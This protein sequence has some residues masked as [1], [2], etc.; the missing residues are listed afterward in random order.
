VLQKCQEACDEFQNHR[1]D[2][3]G[4]LGEG[5]DTEINPTWFRPVLDKLKDITE[6]YQNLL[7]SCSSLLEHEQVAYRIDAKFAE[8]ATAL[9]NWLEVESSALGE[10]K[11]DQSSDVERRLEMV[12]A[13][14]ANAVLNGEQQCDAVKQTSMELCSCLKELGASERAVDDVTELVA[15][16]RNELTELINAAGDLTNQLELEK[17][18]KVGSVGYFLNSNEYLNSSGI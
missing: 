5:S 9:K 15:S 3:A 1:E 14:V 16:L 18:K 8:L 13:F 17:M 2:A 7:S 11:V 10:L 6:R 4:V 12:R